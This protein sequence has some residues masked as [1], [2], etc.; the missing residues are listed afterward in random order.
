[1][2][3]VDELY[4][5]ENSR[6]EEIWRRTQFRFLHPQMY[7]LDTKAIRT[8][9]E[10]RD[11]EFFTRAVR[12]DFFPQGED[13]EVELYFQNA[14]NR[15]INS[16]NLL[17]STNLGD[18]SDYFIS[19]L[20]EKTTL[21]D[22]IRVA[23]EKKSRGKDLVHKSSSRSA[24]NKE[25]NYAEGVALLLEAYQLSRAWGLGCLVSIIDE[26]P[27]VLNS[28]RHIE[29]LREWFSGK[30]RFRRKKETGIPDLPY[31]WKTDAEVRVYGTEEYPIRSRV[32]VLDEE[33]KIKYSSMLMKILRSEEF[34]SGVRDNVGVEFIVENENARKTLLR[35]FQS[36]LHGMGVLERFKL[37]GKTGSAS[38]DPA[39]HP[40]FGGLK[41][42][43][44]PPISITPLW[45]TFNIL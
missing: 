29:L 19:P 26:A 3:L 12:A 39:S 33:G 45:P 20:V 32:K 14:M 34:L 17:C 18:S 10:K 23:R 6:A 43:I 42:L 28:V 2:G 4:P 16:V 8:A 31:S 5:K 40:E 11:F 44:R 13:R 36:T 25:E 30:F 41:F 27:E 38:R 9:I 35:Y 1:M 22:F 7:S 24:P 21:F 37:P 15:G